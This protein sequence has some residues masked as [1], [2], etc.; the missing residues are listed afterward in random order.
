MLI[1]LNLFRQRIVYAM[2]ASVRGG[3]VRKSERAPNQINRTKQNKTK[4]NKKQN[5]TNKPNQTKTKQNK[6]KQSKAKQN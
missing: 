4:Q 6:T 1:Y 3:S 2:L 5:K